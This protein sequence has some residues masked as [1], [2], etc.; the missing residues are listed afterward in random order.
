MKSLS[1]SL[2][3]RGVSDCDAYD[4]CRCCWFQTCQRTKRRANRHKAGAANAKRRK[5]GTANQITTACYKGII[6]IQ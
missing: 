6:A 2:N 3:N 1:I 4:E 5:A